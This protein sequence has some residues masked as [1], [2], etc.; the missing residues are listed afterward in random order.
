FGDGGSSNVQSPTH[1]YAADGDYQVRLTVTTFD[2]RSASISRVLQVRTH[3]VAITR[4]TVPNAASSGQT[5]N[6]SVGVT[7]NR[8]PE[9]VTV[10]LFKS[11]PG[12]GGYQQIGALEQFVA[13]RSAN[14]TTNFDFSYTF[15]SDDAVLGKVT[16][17]AVAVIQSGRDALPA[18]NEAIGSP[19]KASR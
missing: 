7:S 9:T 12:F 5:R 4:F 3:D 19:T 1:R 14:R 18:D 6:I 11:V 8:Y 13:L 10:L 17:R 16:F 15:T 2:G